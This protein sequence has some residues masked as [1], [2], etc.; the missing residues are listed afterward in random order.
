MGNTQ[1]ILLFDGVCNLC[2]GL[3]QFVIKRDIKKNVMFCALQS[4]QAQQLLEK[5]RLPLNNFESVIYIK[6][7]EVLTKSTAVLNLLKDI[8][9]IWKIF[10][11]LIIIPK[12]FRDFIYSIVAKN[13][14]GWFGKT[15]V[16]MTPTAELK[17]RFLN[18]I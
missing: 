17:S 3:V 16:C 1:N 8:G 6:N 4:Q 9:G 15:N 14:Y 5:Y 7:N 13:R 2:N 12:F 11:L 18:D 10:F